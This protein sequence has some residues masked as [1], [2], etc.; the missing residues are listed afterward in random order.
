VLVAALAAGGCSRDDG[1]P[2][3]AG[4]EP[5]AVDTEGAWYVSPFTVDIDGA[6]SVRAAEVVFDECAGAINIL[7]TDVPS[8]A[9]ER[10]PWPEWGYVLFHILAPEADTLNVLYLYCEGPA[11]TWVWHEDFELVMDYEAAT[12]SCSHAVRETAVHDPGMLVL[13]ARPSADQLVVGFTLDGADVSY[14]SAGPG[15]IRFDGED[16]NLYPFEV[17]DCTV[18]CTAEP[19]DGWWELHSLLASDGGRQCFAV[20]YMMVADAT[21]VQ[22]G[23]PVCIDPI[24]KFEDVFLEADWIAEASGGGGSAPEGPRAPGL[25]Y[26]LRPLPPLLRS[27]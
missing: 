19:A 10:T 1:G 2:S 18:D 11:L 13:G 6:G 24:E 22:V 4:D 17:V 3:D 12:G 5:D 25:G 8:V 27:L 16:F 15:S 26:L 14:A 23:Y 20:L 21:T 7:A 9:Y